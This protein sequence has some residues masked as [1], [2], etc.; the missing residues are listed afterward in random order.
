M[1]SKQVESECALKQGP[2]LVFSHS[3]VLTCLAHGQ[4]FAATA[5]RTS[6]HTSSGA[7]QYMLFHHTHN[8]IELKSFQDENVPQMRC[9]PTREQEQWMKHE[10]S[11]RESRTPSEKSYVRETQVLTECALWSRNDD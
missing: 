7:S 5:V 6:S 11:P 10:G 3:P 9:R 2:T 1:Y 4:M 8:S